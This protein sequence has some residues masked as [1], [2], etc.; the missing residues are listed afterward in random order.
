MPFFGGAASGGGSGQGSTVYQPPAQN[1][2]ASDFG[3][4]VQPWATQGAN[5]VNQMGAYGNP[6]QTAYGAS[7]PYQGAAQNLI[8]QYLTGSL[9]GGPQ[10]PFNQFGGQA[11]QQ[12]QNTYGYDLNSLFPQQQGAANALFAS[13]MN[14]LPLGQEVYN[15]NFGLADLYGN[16]ALGMAQPFFNQTMAPAQ[17]ILSSAFDPQGA[18]YN[19]QAG[20]AQNNAAVANAMSGVTGPLAASNT[21][22]A[23]NNFNIGWQ[24]NLLNRQ[25]QGA[26]AYGGLA[27]TALGG[28]EGLTNTG[29]GAYNTLTQGGISGLNAL[30]QG[31][32]TSLLGGSQ[33]G[34]GGANTINQLAMQPYQTGAGLANNALTGLS[35]LTSL[36]GNVANLWQSAYQLPQQVI[37]DLESYMQ[38]GQSASELSGYLGNLGFNQNAQ[39][40]GG[41][42]SGANALFGTN[43]LL[44]GSSGLF[45][46]GGLLGATGLSSLFGGGG[47]SA[48]VDPALLGSLFAF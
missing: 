18:L 21:S 2:A 3:T 10:T 16:Q 29:V 32:L 46:S 8:E 44:G 35:G 30:N 37:N 11:L 36:G 42:L 6:Y 41:A 31:S 48:A 28:Y 14:T 43:S 13:G 47:A 5:T 4:I 26:Q 33:L 34:T 1:V 39:A 17:Q 40:L 12:A 45:G 27:N 9:T 38:L 7:Q 24:N 19:Q 22:N 23:L 25:A 15:Q 20:L